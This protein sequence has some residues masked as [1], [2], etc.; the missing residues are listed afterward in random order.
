MQ[1]YITKNEKETIKLGKKLAASINTGSI[2]AIAGDLG[3]GKTVFVKGIAE[4]L[5][6]NDHITSPTFTLL[7]SY[8]GMDATLHHFDVY[9]VLDERELFEIGFYEYLHSGDICVIEWAELICDL[10]PSHA[11]W[12]HIE[13]TLN[14]VNER[15][16]TIEGM[17][18]A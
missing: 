2:I 8:E 4:G 16:I 14:D 12:V 17:N 7:H 18:E 5:S 15:R 10:I 9:R 1:E 13:R 11:I 6:I 3:S